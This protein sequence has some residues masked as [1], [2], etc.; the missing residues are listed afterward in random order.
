MRLLLEVKAVA[1]DEAALATG[2]Y[3]LSKIGIVVHAEMIGL[4]WRTCDQLRK[5]DAGSTSA[6]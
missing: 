4:D 6:S 1:L 3:G 2:A 5:S